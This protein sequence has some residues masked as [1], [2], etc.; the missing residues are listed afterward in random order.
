MPSPCSAETGNGLAEAETMERRDV[1]DVARRVGLV[2]DQQHR[3]R[4]CA[5]P[6][7]EL[8]VLLGDAGVHVDDE[9]DQVRARHGVLGLRGGERLD[10]AGAVEVAGRVD[11]AEAPAA[12]RRVQLEAIAGHPR[13]VVGDRGAAAVRDG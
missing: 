3:H 10:A 9:H 7:R 13:L 4:R 5:E 1:G 8:R 6:A 2:G 12:P 11:Q